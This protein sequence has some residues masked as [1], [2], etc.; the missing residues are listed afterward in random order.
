MCLA[1][2]R[3]TPVPT[4]TDS[5]PNKTLAC[6]Q[7]IAENLELLVELLAFRVGFLGLSSKAGNLVVKHLKD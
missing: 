1:P 4:S 3:V 5:E 7:A 6:F 2:S